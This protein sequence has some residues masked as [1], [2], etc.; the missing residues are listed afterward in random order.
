MSDPSPNP[1]AQHLQEHTL[2][3]YE[4]LPAFGLYMDQIVSFVNDKVGIYYLPDEKLLTTSM[5]NNYVKQGVI[6]KPEK[7]KYSQDHLAYLIVLCILKKVL[8]IGESGKLIQYQIETRPVQ[9]AYDSFMNALEQ[10]V[11]E[12]F[13]A[14]TAGRSKKT[15][16]S[17]T[18]ENDT[19]L[20]HKIVLSFA[21]K[22]YTQIKLSE[23]TEG[24]R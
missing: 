8:S 11:A 22:I 20:V 14:D 17:P 16:A 5:V 4:D 15:L 19:I 21:N 10:S 13:G 3:R 6:P 7:K 23:H 18:S 24:E 2:P 12:V 1:D 9:Q